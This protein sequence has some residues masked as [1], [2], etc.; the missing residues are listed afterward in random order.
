MSRSIFAVL[1]LSV[2][3]AGSQVAYAQTEFFA[4]VEGHVFDSETLRPL[5]RAN[6]LFVAFSGNQPSQ[7]STS[8]TDS[9]GLFT[10]ALV[11]PVEGEFDAIDLLVQCTLKKA[12]KRV[13]YTTRFYRVP[14]GGR[15]YTRDLYIRIPAGD[16][17]CVSAA[18]SLPSSPLMP[19]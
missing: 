15:V 8:T 5:S 13:T 14:V 18:P 3:L 7:F 16:S 1:A 2:F 17:G 12:K 11:L 9:G 10:N 4:S 19:R 6:V